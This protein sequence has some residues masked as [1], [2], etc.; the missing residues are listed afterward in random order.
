MTVTSRIRSTVL[1]TILAIA[2]VLAVAP[3]ADAAPPE[4]TPA[5]EMGVGPGV[6]G[7]TGSHWN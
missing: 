7:G 4:G 6:R 3:A 1:A 5:H 2:S